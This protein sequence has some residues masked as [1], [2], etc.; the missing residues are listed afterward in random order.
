MCCPELRR[1]GRR[2]A[3]GVMVLPEVVSV[4][5]CHGGGLEEDDLKGGAATNHKPTRESIAYR[6]I[7]MMSLL[8][9]ILIKNEWGKI[10]R[11]VGGYE[12]GLPWW[13]S[14][15]EKTMAWL[16]RVWGERKKIMR[17]RKV[18]YERGRESVCARMGERGRHEQ[19]GRGECGENEGAGKRG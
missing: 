12:G 9:W 15:V 10:Y 1:W 5:A 18:I 16:G 7:R 17:E 19:E 4:M 14:R 3:R 8:L 11:E 6:V 13:S 2:E